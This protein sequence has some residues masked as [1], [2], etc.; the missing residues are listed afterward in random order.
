MAEPVPYYQQI[1]ALNEAV[2]A[3]L[4]ACDWDRVVALLEERRTWMRPENTPTPERESCH[5]GPVL[6]LMETVMTQ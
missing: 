6:A 3:A 4:A 1:V 5:R 2:L